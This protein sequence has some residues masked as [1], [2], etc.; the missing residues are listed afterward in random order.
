M[1]IEAADIIN[2]H[3]MTFQRMNMSAISNQLKN[4]YITYTEKSCHYF[5]VL[6]F[7]STLLQRGKLISDL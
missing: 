2:E 4:W 7:L 3:L 6:L 5:P 1:H